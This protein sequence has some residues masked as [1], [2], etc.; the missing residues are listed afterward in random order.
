MRR[1]VRRYWGTARDS[2]VRPVVSLRERLATALRI[3]AWTA[4]LA[5]AVVLADRA[6]AVATTSAAFAIKTITVD[7]AV[8]TS[9]AH[10]AEVTGARGANVFTLDLGVVRQRLLAEPWVADA[11][12][13]R[14]VPDAVAVRVVER[15][16]VARWRRPGREA[17]VDAAGVVLAEGDE[18]AREPVPVIE[19][20]ADEAA[21]RRA[22]ATLAA[23]REA[24]PD[25]AH[26]L[27]VV[28]VTGTESLTLRAEGQPPLLVSGPESVDEVVGWLSHASGIRK[29]LGP[30]RSVD[31]RWR[32]RLFVM[33]E[34][35]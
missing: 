5:G 25:L 29:A 18:A 3:A 30:V 6:M 26:A 27:R 28:E 11:T 24:V 12:V 31:A 15:T 35:S 13:R 9:A 32:D 21:L 33:P 4:G 34:G 16:P 7:G 17:L 19:G 10:L 8:R 23:L 20:A 2:A 1:P 14:I 22:A